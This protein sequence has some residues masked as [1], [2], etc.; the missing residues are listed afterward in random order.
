[1][2]YDKG[3]L[4]LSNRGYACLVLSLLFQNLTCYLL[5]QV[6]QKRFDIALFFPRYGQWDIL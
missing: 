5:F 1:M 3:Q 2:L 4:Q 6:K